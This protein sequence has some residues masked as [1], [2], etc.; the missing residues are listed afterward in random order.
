MS[1]LGVGIAPVFEPTRRHY[2]TRTYGFRTEFKGSHS[3]QTGS[4]LLLVKE[5]RGQGEQQ[6]SLTN[7]GYAPNARTQ[8]G[9]SRRLGQPLHSMV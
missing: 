9:P 8:L 3:E 2:N 6:R 5:G 1:V 7:D 4:R